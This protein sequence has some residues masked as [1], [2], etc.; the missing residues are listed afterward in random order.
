MVT[1]KLP[2][3]LNSRA[4]EFTQNTWSAEP[5]R[6]P[7]VPSG[8][9]VGTPVPGSAGATAHKIR[10]A[11]KN[12][13]AR[14]PSLCASIVCM[15]ACAGPLPALSS[16]SNR[17]MVA[18]EASKACFTARWISRASGKNVDPL[19][20]RASGTSV[21]GRVAGHTYRWRFRERGFCSVSTLVVNM[22]AISAD[23]SSSA[24]ASASASA[25]T[26]KGALPSAGA[27]TPTPPSGRL[28]RPEAISEVRAFAAPRGP[29]APADP[30]AP[31]G[32]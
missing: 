28:A 2:G 16:V 7:H 29:E 23:K 9:C 31:E 15:D 18:P 5:Q 27:S 26:P 14:T 4:V 20:S 19:V 13:S 8:P 11:N 24:S 25:S 10:C 30:A 3:S 1:N 22:S 6:L 17:P 21:P 32:G 12:S